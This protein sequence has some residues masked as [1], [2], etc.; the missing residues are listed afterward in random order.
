MEESTAL[1][2]GCGEPAGIERTLAAVLAEV[3]RSEQVPV[4]G[5]FFDD[6]GADSLVMAH[7]CARVRKRADL[8]SVSMRDVYR[9]PTIRSL[10]TALAD[11]EPVPRSEPAAVLTAPESPAPAPS[12][13][14]KRQY[15]LCGA[16]QFLAF[17]GYVYL[18]A[19][20]TALG[21][22]WISAGSGALDVYLRSVLFGGATF[23]VL[24]VL[25]VLVKWTLVG[26][27]T[28]QRIPVWSVAYVRFWIVKTLVRADPMVLFSG[29]PLY[30]LYL[31]ALGAKVGRGAVVLSRNVPVC[32]DLFTIGDGTVIRKDSFFSCYRAHA[33]QIQTGPV[34]IGRNVLVSEATVLDIDTSLGDGA[35][36]GHASSLHRGQAVPDGEHWHGSPAQ[37]TDVDYQVVGRA[38]CGAVRRATHSL[39]QLLLALAV[40]VP[41]AVGGVAALLVEVPQLST[42]L[43]PGPAVFA[44]GSFYLEALAMSFVLVFGAVPAGLLVLTALPRLLSLTITPGRTY[45]LYGFH[46]EVH[47]TIT[48]LT[49][50]RFLKRLFGDSSAIV[51]YLRG[52]GYDLSRVEQTGSNFGTEM[53]HETPYLSF[54]G[55]GTMAADGLS[56]MNA[57]F[58]ST[59]FR[60]SRVSIGPRNFLGNRIAYPTR[61]RTGDNCLLA[62][63]VMVPVDG[64]VREGVGLLGSPS[65]EI[66]RSVLRDSTFDRLKGREELRHGLAAKNRHNVATMAWYL[67]SRWIFAFVL[68]LLVT[69]AAELYGPLGVS[70]LM[71]ADLLVVLFTIAYFVLVER[72]VTAV[73]PL[74]PLFCSIYTPDFWQHERYW[75]V[76]SETYLRMLNGTPFKNVAWRLL[77]VRLGRMVFDDGCHLTERAMAAIGDGCTLNLGSVVQCHSQEDGA[78]KSDRSTIGSGCTLGVGAFVHYGVTV[79]DGAVLAPDSFLMKGEAVPQQAWWGGNPARPIRSY[80]EDEVRSA[81]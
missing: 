3:V 73:R 75:K 10:A 28:P 38:R 7:F 15:V 2:D 59:A 50:W 1:L 42:A 13:A 18:L 36:L 81:P 8:P 29:S 60:V 44:D 5:H 12:A 45:R 58:S 74:K 48:L 21:Y 23:L 46:F 27:W 56:I 22:G 70:G 34:T 19:F 17:L 26:R 80:G 32:T 67:L 33:G 24:C 52:L 20:G 76:P 30:L 31:R 6:L 77:G 62:T 78:F 11:A 68:I 47:R 64:E 72:V 61:G 25:P 41:L 63:K 43:E 51:H 79:G 55:R 66:P 16:L 14:G 65:F 37:R 35:Q 54:V 69:A 57:D 9:H 39:L 4:D 71:L 49:N 53:K 40:Y